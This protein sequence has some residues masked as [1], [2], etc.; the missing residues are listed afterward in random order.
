MKD[1]QKE[2]SSRLAAAYKEKLGQSSPGR[3]TGGKKDD[4][5]VVSTRSESTNS[6]T[7]ERKLKLLSKKISPIT[8]PIRKLGK[9][10]KREAMF[11]RD[12][13]KNVD[14]PDQQQQHEG[15]G[16]S[17][18]LFFGLENSFPIST[19]SK[20]VSKLGQ[21]IP[22]ATVTKG[23]SKLGQIVPTSTVTKGA[24]KLGQL[25]PTATMARG[26]SKLGQMVPIG[27]VSKGASMLGQL[28]AKPF[29]IGPVREDFGANAT[30]D[31]LIEIVS[32]FNLP[33][34]ATS[35]YD[36]YVRVFDGR[37]AI[38]KTKHVPKKYVLWLTTVG[39]NIFYQHAHDE[40]LATD[41]S[42][43]VS[44]SLEST[45]FGGTPLLSP[46]LVSLSSPLSASD[47]GRHGVYAHL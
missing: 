29:G 3:A 42:T 36:P 23:A 20:G 38:Y 34:S 18:S 44:T 26:A 25:V 16:S 21:F 47:K 41:D 46:L 24:S 8:S 33:A 40:L 43:P 37:K 1:L 35:K 10:V 30:I 22:I 19:M 2:R 27:T 15:D 4:T 17:R 32:A 31:L 11:W 14:L 5:L 39:T 9:K 7:S 13:D 28:I 45:V 12:G 6:E